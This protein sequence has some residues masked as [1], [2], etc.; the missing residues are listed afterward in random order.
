MSFILSQDLLVGWVKGTFQCSVKCWSVTFPLPGS[1]YISSVQA[2]LFVSTVH[3]CI[4]YHKGICGDIDHFLLTPKRMIIAE[5]HSLSILKWI[6]LDYFHLNCHKNEG[7]TVIS[8]H[9]NFSQLKLCSLL[10]KMGMR[11]SIILVMKWANVLKMNKINLK[12]VPKA[13]K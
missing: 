9:N 3:S 8:S 6:N 11:L 5:G 4:A 2:G 10:Y 12:H 1:G 7:S 13:N